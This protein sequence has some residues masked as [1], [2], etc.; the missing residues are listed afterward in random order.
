MALSQSPSRPSARQ[1]IEEIGRSGPTIEDLEEECEDERGARRTPTSVFL[2]QDDR[3]KI[4]LIAK[5]YG[6]SISKI[7]SIMISM[8]LKKFDM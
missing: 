5:K 7:C 3:K 8:N 1:L 6:Q 4:T 2:S